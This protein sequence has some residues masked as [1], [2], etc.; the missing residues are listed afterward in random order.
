MKLVAFMHQLHF[1]FLILWF[2]DSKNLLFLIYTR[3]KAVGRT[4]LA[5][6]VK[7]LREKANRKDHSMDQGEDSNDYFYEACDDKYLRRLFY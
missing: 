5:I 6:P 4:L 3:L 1:L 7:D 2:S